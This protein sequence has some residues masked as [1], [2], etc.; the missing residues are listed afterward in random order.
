MQAKHLVPNAVTLANIVFGFLGIVAAAQGRFEQSCYLLFAAAL[1]DMLD[2]RLARLLN[3]TSKFGM[4]LDS[5][6]DAISFGVAPGFLVYLASLKDLGIPGLAISALYVLCGVLR[7]ARFNVTTSELAKV[8]FLGC[9]I[10]AAGG[11]ILSMVLV[12]E[13]LP[14]WLTAFGTA[15]VGLS[16]VSTL[17][18]PKFGSRACGPPGFMLWGAMALFIALLVRPSALTWHLWNGWNLVMLATNYVQLYRR[19][20]LGPKKAAA[21][22]P[23][24]AEAGAGQ[25]QAGGDAG[26]DLAQSLEK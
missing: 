19:G 13:S 21:A 5:L 12:R 17:K 22:F 24:P 23:A 10:P 9:P 4:E 7:L 11:Y 16:M 6:S 2:G 25:A 26:P 15:F 14:L 20:H 1:C 18:V 8:T 3:A